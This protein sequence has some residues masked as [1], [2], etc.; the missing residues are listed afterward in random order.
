MEHLKFH[1][2]G[3]TP[4]LNIY[5][6]IKNMASLLEVFL[7]GNKL[8]EQENYVKNLI[9]RILPALVLFNG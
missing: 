7:E 5:I 4:E 2:D 6:A 9:L 3:K 1:E 8:I